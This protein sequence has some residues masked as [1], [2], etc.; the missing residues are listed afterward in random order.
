MTEDLGDDLL[1][2]MIWL[3][4]G[5]VAIAGAGNTDWLEQFNLDVSRQAVSQPLLEH[6]DRTEFLGG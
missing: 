1:P 3:T 4:C 5:V 2:A 6:V